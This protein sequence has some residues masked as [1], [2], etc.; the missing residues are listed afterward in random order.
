MPKKHSDIIASD[1]IHIPK[2]FTEADNAT[3]LIKDELG[4]LEY[5]DLSLLGAVGPEGPPGTTLE[6]VLVSDIDSPDLTSKGGVLGDTIV[7]YEVIASGANKSRRYVFDTEVIT[8]NPP[9]IV[10]GDSG[11]WVLGEDD[12]YTNTILFDTATGVISGCA[13]TINADNTKFDMAAGT[14]IVVDNTT[15]PTKPILT[16]VVIPERLGVTP[17]YLNSETATFISIDINGDIVQRSA[18]ATP[19]Q[20]RDTM[21]C[22][23]VSHPDQI[24]INAVLD[25]PAVTYGPAHQTHDLMQAIGFFSTGGNQIGGINGTL[26][27]SKSAGGG[28]A[29]GENFT[30]N[31]KDPHNISMPALSP[32]TYFQILQDATPVATSEILD[33]T[34]Y[35]NNGTL[36]TVPA[37]NDATISYVY[38][39]PNNQLV[40]LFGQEVFAN[41]AQAVSAAGTESVVL[42]PDIESG[43]L[44]LA[45]II[46]RKDTTDITDAVSALILPSTAVSSGG[47]SVPNMQQTYDISNEPEITTDSVRNAV[48]YKQ[49]SGASEHL[50]EFIDDALVAKGHIAT[51]EWQAVTQAYS[52]TNTLSDAATIA[53]DCSLG[54]VHTVTLTD[55]RTLGAPTNLKD[56]ATYIWIIK[57]DATGSRTLGYNSVFKFSEGTAPTLSTAANAVDILTG[58]SDGTNVYVSLGVDFK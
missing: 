30:N 49:G 43:G 29:L 38:V 8:P 42:P 26:T 41:L 20:R 15:D 44:L 18:I 37:N 50:L 5:R 35:D 39:F 12:S 34:Q 52:L 48:S 27:T 54:N 36:T 6:S 57:Q 10:T 16:R 55:N 28:F 4:S 7:V 19:T 3:A 47:S 22:G 33:P 40:Y 51:D 11:T 1:D 31:P 13:I 32:V 45:R 2:G 56:G 9:L 25:A 58:V 53:T 23:L 24:S 21:T 46:M 17:A 14:G